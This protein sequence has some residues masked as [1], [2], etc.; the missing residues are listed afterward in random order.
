MAT[1]KVENTLTENSQLL[2]NPMCNKNQNRS[3][4]KIN[5]ENAIFILFYLERK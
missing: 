3:L 2:V 5:L 1:T 4:E